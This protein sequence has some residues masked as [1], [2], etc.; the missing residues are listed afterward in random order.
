VAELG[1]VSISAASE[2]LIESA[3]CPVLVVPRGRAVAFDGSGV[4]VA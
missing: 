1:R 3:T 4:A 2:N